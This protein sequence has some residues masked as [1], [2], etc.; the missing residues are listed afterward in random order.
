MAK[1][2]IESTQETE[3]KNGTRERKEYELTPQAKSKKFAVSV[4]TRKF[5]KS[6]NSATVL[7]IDFDGYGKECRPENDEKGLIV[8]NGSHTKYEATLCEGISQDGI[9]YLGVDIWLDRDYY[10]REW[11]TKLEKI[12]LTR[13]GYLREVK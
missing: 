5:K 8:M 2:E 4:I 11:F 12:M 13:K 9:A 7:V 1:N 6:G 10:K 3:M